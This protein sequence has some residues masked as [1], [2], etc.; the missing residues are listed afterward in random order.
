MLVFCSDVKLSEAAWLGDHREAK[1][2]KREI[3][4]SIIRLNIAVT[5]LIT[6]SKQVQYWA[7][8]G[9]AEEKQ[10]DEKVA[11]PTWSIQLLDFAF[12]AFRIG[13]FLGLNWDET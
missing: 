12:F 7:D 2:E 11:D 3:T 10:A 8:K 5:A 4:H 9:T 13:W 6:L 1:E